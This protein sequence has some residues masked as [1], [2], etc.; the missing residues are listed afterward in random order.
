MDLCIGQLY[1]YSAHQKGKRKLCF[2]HNFLFIFLIHIFILFYN[3]ELY[4]I[5]YILGE[6]VNLSPIYGVW[7]SGHLFFEQ[8]PS[9]M[10]WT[11][12]KVNQTSG[13]ER[14]DFACQTTLS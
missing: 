12:T 14:I 9:K 3:I 6:I 1:I 10:D 2:L 11:N 7:N 4:L 8:Y 5:E 13:S